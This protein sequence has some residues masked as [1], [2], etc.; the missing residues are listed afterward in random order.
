MMTAKL[1]HALAQLAVW[2]KVWRE[3][4]FVSLCDMIFLLLRLCGRGML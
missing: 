1:R 3:T 4:T 2:G